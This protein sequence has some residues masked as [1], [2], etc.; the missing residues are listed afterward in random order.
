MNES[1]GCPPHWWVCRATVLRNNIHSTPALC[2][3]C[4]ETREFKHPPV[5]SPSERRAGWAASE[6]VEKP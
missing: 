4:G 1:G 5:I 3:R 2:L 6:G